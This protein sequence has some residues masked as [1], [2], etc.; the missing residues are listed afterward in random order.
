MSQ[1][2]RDGATP[3]VHVLMMYFCRPTQKLASHWVEKSQWDFLI[4]CEINSATNTV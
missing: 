3:A 2:C 4:D 1:E